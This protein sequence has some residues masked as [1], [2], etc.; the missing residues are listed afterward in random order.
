MRW[1][2]ILSITAKRF[3]E[4]TQRAIDRIITIGEAR[5]K[6]ILGKTQNRDISTYADYLVRKAYKQ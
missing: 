5:L 6:R 3:T 4:L 2:P 1:L